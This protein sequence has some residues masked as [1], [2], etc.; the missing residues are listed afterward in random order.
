MK[1]RILSLAISVSMILATVIP[2]SSVAI[3][4][5]DVSLS[6]LVGD[7]DASGIVDSAD[8]EVLMNKVLDSDIQMPIETF[9]D[10][11]FLIADTDGDKVLTAA[12]AAQI[13]KKVSSD[14]YLM[15]AE[16]ST[17]IATETTTESSTEITTEESTETTTEIL[18]EEEIVLSDGASY[19]TYNMEGS[20]IIDNTN[21]IVT[22]KIPGTYN[23]SGTLTNGQLVVD[24]DTSYISNNA[25]LNLN[26]VNITNNSGP[27]IYGLNGDL[28]ISAKKG[29]TNTLSDGTPTEFETEIDEN[30]NT[31]TTDEPDACIFSHDGIDLKGKGELI[32]NGNYANGISGKDEIEIK[33][34]S[35]TVNAVAN[36]IKGKD[37]VTV[38]SGT[39]DLTA[40]TG[41]GIRCTKGDINVLDG[42]VTV[43]GCDDGLFTK[44]GNIIISGGTL[45]ITTVP[46]GTADTTT[47]NYDAIHTKAGIITISGGSITTRSYCDGI[48]AASDMI[49]SGE[50]V[51]NVTTTGA[52]SSS[53]SS[54]GF[55]GWNNNTT[56]DISAKGIKSDT[57]LTIEGGTITVD[58]TD[59]S[60]HTN[61]TI[62]INGGTFTLSSGDDGIHADSVLNINDG[63][64]KVSKSYEGV[65]GE[66]IYFNGGKVIIYADDDSINAAGGNDG[67]SSGGFNTNADGY[68][69]INGGYIYCE[70]T[71]DGDGIDSNGKIVMNGGVLL[72]NGPTGNGNGA[73]DFGDKS[74][75][76]FA[77]NGGELIAVGSSGMAE[78]PTT[79]VSSGYTLT[80]GMSSGGN[81]GGSGSGGP[82]GNRPG[83]GGSSSAS[84]PAGTL[85][86]LTDSSGNVIMSFKTKN[87]YSTVVMSS[88][89]IKSG[90]TYTLY[91]G[92]TYSGTLDD[93]NYGT[94]GTI[95]G[96]TKLGSATVSAKV[97][98]LS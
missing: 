50:P 89:S 27:A 8:A 63:D 95:S 55:P 68:I 70:N 43:N 83:Q 56:A 45:D 94:G 21:D 39:L 67:S 11:W 79:S 28:K 48:Q 20:V 91:S 18:A 62:T 34:L 7:V 84:I 38:T 25:E 35:L 4:A 41:D 53:S 54:G 30:G 64:I 10:D 75:D 22:I 2:Y 73:M 40:K 29:T 81:Q 92:G 86:T 71:K 76:S 23:I 5:A 52:I 14:S 65:E 31:V 37:Y 77:Y 69:E 58:S 49:I 60:L 97:T 82:G 6:Y 87:A 46:S 98:A 42:T 80:Y 32:I 85:L 15:P 61:D 17:E 72:I 26:G 24:V 44:V 1:K 13:I 16:E 47:Y 96:G 88:D 59:D 9:T 19:S 66:K 93:Q 36:A 12:D 3:N 57:I 90:S 33:N 51:I 74:T 78:S